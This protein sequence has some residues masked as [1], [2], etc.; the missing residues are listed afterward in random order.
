MIKKN[1][2]IAIALISQFGINIIVH[3]HKPVALP[4]TR[5]ILL[6]LAPVIFVPDQR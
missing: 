4:F 1:A 3:R 5:K 2:K 6:K